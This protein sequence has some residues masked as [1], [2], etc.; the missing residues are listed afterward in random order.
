M[1]R[2]EGLHQTHEYSLPY[3]SPPRVTRGTVQ[4]LWLL[5]QRYD[6]L[7]SARRFLETDTKPFLE[8]VER[9]FLGEI[10]RLS[11]KRTFLADNSHFFLALGEIYH[12]VSPE[13][14]EAFD[15]S[16]AV[17]SYIPEY[18]KHEKLQHGFSRRALLAPPITAQ[19][20][21]DRITELQEVNEDLARGEKRTFGLSDPAAFRYMLYHNVGS[22]LPLF[23]EQ[24]ESVSLQ[25]VNSDV[26][27]LL[28]DIEIDI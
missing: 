19:D 13:D 9:G 6:N 24:Y 15:F 26:E 20:F 4:S 23:T 14:R 27:Y 17:F 8:G 16:N 5:Q 21:Y 7:G 10:G 12:E 28:R 3:K 1:A 11:Q 22:N 2:F 25:D 18:G